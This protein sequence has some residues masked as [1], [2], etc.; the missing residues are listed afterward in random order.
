MWKYL[1]TMVEGTS[2]NIDI[3]VLVIATQ[4]STFYAVALFSECPNTGVLHTTA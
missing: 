2:Y 4:Y 3:V 1:A